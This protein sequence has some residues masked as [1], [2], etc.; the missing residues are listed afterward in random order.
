MANEAEILSKR[1]WALVWRTRW[2]YAIRVTG[3]NPEAALYAGISPSTVAWLVMLLSGALAG[4]LGLNELMGAE[5]RILLDFPG[6]AGFV[7][8]TGHAP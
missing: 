2:G 8:G 4:G 5:H 3:E 1:V 7:Y 6:G